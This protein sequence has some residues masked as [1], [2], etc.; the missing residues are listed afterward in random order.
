M[1]FLNTD[2]SR[3]TTQ[4]SA[5]PQSSRSFMKRNLVFLALLLV[6]LPV[7]L[8]V[9]LY[10]DQGRARFQKTVEASLFGGQYT[11]LYSPSGD[12]VF[13]PPKHKLF[14]D[15]GDPLGGSFDV[16][17]D[18]GFISGSAIPDDP[19]LFRRLLGSHSYRVSAQLY[20]HDE[21]VIGGPRFFGTGASPTT[22][23][24]SY[25]TDD[26]VSLVRQFLRLVWEPRNGHIVRVH[27]P[28]EFVD[29][30]IRTSTWSDRLTSGW[31]VVHVT[32]VGIALAA[33]T[34]VAIQTLRLSRMYRRQKLNRCAMCGYPME[35]NASGACSECGL[36][37]SKPTG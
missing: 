9:M 2:N 16:H 31:F 33:L 23:V 19:P 4:D 18:K 26:E 7:C 5:R 1:R 8:V 29:A 22:P 15:D 11:I 17:L 37:V 10:A 24:T 35:G 21:S 6:S 25:A 12:R 34:A 14:D 36:A 13:V 30:L 27:T 3:G 32:S 20:M 28:D